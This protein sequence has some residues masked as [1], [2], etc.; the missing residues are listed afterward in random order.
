MKLLGYVFDAIKLLKNV[1]RWVATC[2]FGFTLDHFAITLKEKV[3]KVLFT[4]KGF[5]FKLI[6]YLCLKKITDTTIL[7]LK[8][9]KVKSGVKRSS[10]FCSWVECYR[11]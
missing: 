3:Q 5:V 9:R 1:E 11:Q 2:G 7:Y 10:N 8:E 6:L 4:T